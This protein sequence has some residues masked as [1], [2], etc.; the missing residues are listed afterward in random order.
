MDIET[1][2]VDSHGDSFIGFGITRLLG[3]DLIARFKQIN[4]MKLYLPVKGQ[5]DAYPQL[6]SALTRPIRRD[7]I[8]QQYELMVKYATAIRLGT[9]STEALLRRFTQNT[10]HPAYAAMLESRGIAN[11]PSTSF[12]LFRATTR[13]TTA[14]ILTSQSPLPLNPLSIG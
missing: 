11:P 7:L 6:A 1:N 3:F 8:E 4:T 14:P 5:S 9:A 12:L 2:H 10:T 13:P